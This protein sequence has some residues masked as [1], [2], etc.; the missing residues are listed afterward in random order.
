MRFVK[1]LYPKPPYERSGTGFEV[2]TLGGRTWWKNGV[3]LKLA[4]AKGIERFARE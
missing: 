3:M 1:I 2:L 4:L